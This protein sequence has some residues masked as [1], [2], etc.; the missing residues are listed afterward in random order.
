[1]VFRRF[2]AL[3]VPLYLF[4]CS[5]L[6][7]AD[8]GRDFLL[9][10]TGRLGE[11]GSVIGIARQ[12]FTREEGDNAFAFEPL[13][14]WTALDW[15]SVEI[16]VD[17]EK[18][19][20]ESFTYEA[21]SPG[22]RLRFTPTDHA[23]GLGIAARAELAATDEE[24]NALR[25]TSLTSYDVADW[26]IAANLTFEKAEGTPSEWAYGVGLRREL[27]HHLGLGIELAGR[28]EGER[29][30][31]VVAGVFYEPRH[32][33]QI[34]GG[35]GTSLSSEADPTAKTALVWLFR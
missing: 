12:D 27:L 33:V 10:Q 30:G 24:N 2:R 32:G 11:V 19:G 20:D 34:N 31:E 3:V 25:L 28:L 13:L 29:S 9:V 4:F 1:M 23:L 15:L 18:A 5:S 21:T 26:L 8:H 14:S 22:L 6:T 35:L 17:A 16:N 7:W